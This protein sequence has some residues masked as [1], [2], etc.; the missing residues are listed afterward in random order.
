[1][2]RRRLATV[3]AAAV[4]VVGCGDDH[5]APDTGT[6]VIL[7]DIDDHGLAALWMAQAPNLKG[8]IARGTLAYSRVDVPTHSNQ[9]NYTLLTGQYPD[10]HNVPHNAWLSRAAGFTS[11]V[12]IPGIELGDYALWDVNPLRTRGDTVYAAVRAAG[13]RSAYVGEL[14]P[15][16]VGADDVYL[17]INGVTADTPLGPLTLDQK[18]AKSILTSSLRYPQTVVDKYHYDGPPDPGESQLHF[19]LRDA[20]RIVRASGPGHPLPAFMFLWDFIALDD[21]PTSRFGTDSPEVAAIVDDYDAGLGELLTALDEKKLLDRTNILFTLDHGK[22]DTHNQAALGTRGKTATQ[23]ADGQL[24]SVI[25]AQGATFG[26]TTSDYAIVNED[27][28]AQ[29]YAR[30]QGAGTPAGQIEQ[31]NVRNKLL[32]LVQSGMLAGVDTTRTM[33]ADG[34]NGTRTF[35]DFRAS[36]PNQPDIIV[37]P[38]DDWTLNQVD[39][40]NAV[41]GPFTEHA[42]RPYARH[43]GFSPDELY[44][45]L[46]MAGP[47]F[48]QGAVLPHPVEHAD[49]APTALAAL[50][51]GARLAT[52]ARGPIRA[53]LVDDPGETIPLP[54]PPAGSRD[55]VLSSSGYLGPT[56]RQGGAPWVVLID[57][58]GLYEDEVFNDEVLADAASPLRALAARGTRFEDCWTRY[59]DWPVTE[60]QMLVGGYPSAAGTPTAEDD[61]AQLVMPGKGLLAMPPPANRVADPFAYD[62]WRRDAP[63]DRD[64]LF[65]VVP[66]LGYATALVGDSDFHTKHIKPPAT[67][68][69]PTDPMPL[70]SSLAGANGRFF[71]VV[72]MGG[73]RTADRHDPAAIAELTALAQ[74]VADLASANMGALVIIT[75][76]GATTID[77]DGSD[78]YGPGTSRHVPLIL[79]GP[80]VR[81][82]VVSGQPATPADIPA[83]ILFAMGAPTATDF[84]QGTWAAGAAVD[85]I[86]QPLP[87][88]A[89]EGHALLR[90]YLP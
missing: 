47:A 16:E 31:Q 84:V 24:A 27:G 19:T 33:T 63:F 45:P 86:P 37:F 15:F 10:G 51:G 17:T 8:L 88:A 32:L 55:V 48:K 18:S 74:K 69:P 1:M 30:V 78:F 64:S 66:A 20:A 35:H 61:P 29:L 44:V 54:D 73:P 23:E 57:V 3:L 40:D 49:I 79:V 42:G 59:R 83:T 85:G 89:S 6:H 67:V 82:G 56:V 50:G 68:L 60:Y 72:S 5:A 22:V 53:A 11:P 2:S 62:L 14:P 58:A 34:L 80:N 90:A 75:S 4:C 9:N 71:A 13:M 26:L 81:A 36:S 52:A 7:I 70:L 41:P 77:D 25:A 12:N 65:D 21:D 28:D 46:I 43:G 39:K 87:V 38:K 76:R